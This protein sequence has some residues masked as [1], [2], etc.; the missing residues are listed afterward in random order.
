MAL[1][2]T[3]SGSRPKK[4][5][6]S[7]AST[8]QPATNV[9]L[10]RIAAVGRLQLRRGHRYAAGPAE[11][12]QQHRQGGGDADQVHRHHDRRVVAEADAKK[13]AETMLTRLDTTSGRLAVSAMKPAAITKASVAAGEKRSASSMAMT[14]GRQD[15]RR[16][17]VGEQRRDGGA[18]QHDEGEQL[19]AAAAAPARHVQRRPLEEPRLVQQQADDDDGDKGGGGVPDDLPDHRNIGQ[20][21]RRQPAAP[22][23]APSMRSSRRRGPWVAR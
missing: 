1:I 17:V 9:A 2:G 15:Q 16:T 18:Q 8:T 12:P 7:S 11:E 23:T 19:A 22:A 3:P 21:A 14:I 5:T 4:P 20:A 13:S 10:S 6:S